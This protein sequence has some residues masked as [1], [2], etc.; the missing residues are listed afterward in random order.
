MVAGR[1]PWI[2]LCARYISDRVVMVEMTS[3]MS[4]RNLFLER[5]NVRRNCSDSKL[6]GSAGTLLE[7]IFTQKRSDFTEGTSK[8]LIAPNSWTTR[9]S[10]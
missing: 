4:I 6:G 5:F 8:C 10:I 9:S 1:E 2:A 7:C 3:K